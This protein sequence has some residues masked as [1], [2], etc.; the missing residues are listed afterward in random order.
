MTPSAKP[1]AANFLGGAKSRLLPASIPFRFFA[2]AV[3]FHVAFWLGLIW[4]APEIPNF[5]LGPGRVLAVLHLLTLGVF[6][7]TAF[8]AAFQLLPVA[9]N[10]RISCSRSLSIALSGGFD[11]SCP[12]GSG[13]FI[14]FCIPLSVSH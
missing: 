6:A 1:A 13:L 3:F 4:A 7:A 2:G 10:R 14:P 9:T 12:P 5:V 11:V 8:G